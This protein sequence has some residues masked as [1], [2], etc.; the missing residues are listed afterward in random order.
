MK[1]SPSGLQRRQHT[2]SFST[3]S[4]E[5]D[6]HR[7]VRGKHGCTFN[8]AFVLLG[9][10][11]TSLFLNKRIFYIFFY[12]CHFSRGYSASHRSE[13]TL[14]LR[15]GRRGGGFEMYHTEL[16]VF[17]HFPQRELFYLPPFV[18]SHPTIGPTNGDASRSLVKKTRPIFHLIAPQQT[19]CNN[20]PLSVSAFC[21]P[22]EESLL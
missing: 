1:G 2:L 18:L 3:F 12:S 14:L 15:W 8:G 7:G 9:S 10:T 5:P 17:L 21:T 6:T 13:P 20:A 11:F 4:K 22:V 16:K 19:R